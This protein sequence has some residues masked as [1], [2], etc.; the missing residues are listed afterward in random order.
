MESGSQQNEL[1]NQGCNDQNLL[2]EM[3]ATM[4]RRMAEQDAK[5]SEQMDEIRNLRQQL[6]LQSE[7][8]N[9]GNTG[10]PSETEAGDR[11]KKQSVSDWK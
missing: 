9:E 11:S 1:G 6:Q 2:A 7:G 3:L 4:Q 10:N 5:I 8:R